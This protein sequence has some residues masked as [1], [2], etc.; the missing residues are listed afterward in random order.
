MCPE[1]LSLS[2]RQ[3]SKLKSPWLLIRHRFQPVRLRKTIWLIM[4]IV[5]RNTNLQLPG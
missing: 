2:G 4:A 1:K 3:T 5:R